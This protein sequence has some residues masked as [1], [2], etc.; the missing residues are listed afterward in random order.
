MSNIAFVV[1][2]TVSTL[3]HL[4]DSQFVKLIVVENNFFLY[5]AL[6]LSVFV[7]IIQIVL[8]SN[9]YRTTISNAQ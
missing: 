7:I 6:D 3:Q 5:K 8:I 4:H 1:A 9:L 2:L